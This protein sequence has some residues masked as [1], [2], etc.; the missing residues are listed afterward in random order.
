MLMRLSTLLIASG[1]AGLTP[2][3][4]LVT[5]TEYASLQ[6]YFQGQHGSTTLPVQ[7]MTYD[8]VESAFGPRI[9]HST[10]VYDFHRGID[11]DGNEG[12]NILAATNGVFWEY[13]VFDGG[14]NTVILRHDF[15]SPKTINGNQYTH[16]YTY[17]MHLWDDGAGGNGTSTD[18]IVSG[19][20]SEKT[21]PGQGTQ[22]TAGQ[23]IGEMGHSGSSG[24]E[25]YANHLH[26]D[27]RVGTTNSL[28]FQLDNPS[29]TQYGF[30]PHMNP[31]LLYAPYTFGG[32]DYDPTLEAD[33]EYTPNADLGVVYTCNDEQPLLNRFEVAIVD[34]SDDSI[35]K[36]YVL[37][38]NLRTGF[39]ATNQELLDSQDTTNPYIAP[40]DFGDT[41]IAFSTELVLPESWLDGYD[42]DGYRVE[43]SAF[44][45]W[46]NETANSFTVVPEPATFALLIGVGALLWAKRR[47]A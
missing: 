11:I 32:P 36:T 23:H 15:D 28:I 6:S 2:A 19:W 40:L 30:D 47:R 12:D 42:N 33:G 5:T 38:Y 44:D 29:T 35:V 34:E 16:Y 41:A 26:M 9:Q 4:A 22:I 8:A 31:M 20:T 3:F 46:G 10:D 43:I 21:N 18:D 7:G 27:L 13:R 1:L 17:Y 45:I 25:D 24:G 39:D 14:G 37:D